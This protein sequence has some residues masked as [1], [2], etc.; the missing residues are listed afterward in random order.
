MPRDDARQGVDAPGL[1]GDRRETDPRLWGA[2]LGHDDRRREEAARTIA[3][4]ERERW[5]ARLLLDALPG[6][7]PWQRGNA[8]SALSLLGDIRFSA[9]YFLPEMIYVPAGMALLGDAAF[10]DERPVHAVEVRGFALAQ[11]PVVQAA[12]QVFVGATGHRA[13]RGWRGRLRR[14]EPDAALRNAPAVSVSARDAE[15]YCVWLSNETG[16]RYRLPTEAE[17]VLAARG[18]GDARRYPWGDSYS[19]GLANVWGDHPLGRLSAVGLFA[20]GSGPSGHGDLAGNVWEWCSSLWWPYPYR[21][22]DGREDPGASQ[23][24]RVMHGGSWRSRPLSA[25][26]SA[27]QG[28]LPDDSF[29]VVGFRVA[30][31]AASA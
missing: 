28:E 30:R 22:D 11:Y 3:A 31:D 4:L 5:Y 21:R 27:R 2:L 20:E 23:E 25:R 29:V 9:P 7:Q 26:C 10:P 17:W 13:P 19:E 8:G 18:D 16:Y 24:R 1:G 6:L 14:R 12:Y 15:A